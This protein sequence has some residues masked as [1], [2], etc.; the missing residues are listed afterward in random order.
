MNS[1][2]FGGKLT[3]AHVENYA[4]SPH[5]KNGRFENL[6]TTTMNVNLWTMPK[7]V[8]QQLSA[9]T[10]RAPSQPIPV[11]DFDRHRFTEGTEKIKLI[12]YGHS[13]VLIRVGNYTIFIDPMLGPNAAPIAPFP[14]PR[15]SLD[16]LDL[17]DTFPELDFLLLSHDH[18]DHLD[19]ASIQK[20]KSKTRYYL[21]ALG[22]QRHLERWGINPAI[23]KEFDW[24]DQYL[25]DDLSIT[26]T[27]TRHFSGRGVSDRAKSLWGGW[28][29]H[30]RHTRLLFSGDGGYGAH[31]KDIG[32]R[33]GPF[34][35]GL[36][37]CGQYHN[38]W[39][40]IHL[41]PEE[42]VLAALDARVKKVLPVHWAGFLLAP[43]HW[44]DPIIRFTASAQA[45]QVDYI[46]PEVGQLISIDDQLQ[47]PWWDAW[48]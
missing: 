29:L 39:H 47:N 26:F 27:P 1:I 2:Q 33:L 6:E 28:A 37:E 10:Q 25:V 40:M 12:W 17:I 24:W 19:Y 43:H 45:H 3:P 31:F 16:T 22:M 21:V 42:T 9:R 13:A 44:L 34:D 38:L 36:M 48:R 18:Y 41:F 8:Y 14:T 11:R 5:W 30:A 23:I 20:L 35:F 4:R 15:F 46:T 7:V 32:A